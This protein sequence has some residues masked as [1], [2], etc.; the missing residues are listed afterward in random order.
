MR[1]LFIDCLFD[2]QR[3]A[4]RRGHQASTLR[5]KVYQVL[6]YLLQ[7]RHRVVSRD[8]LISQVWEETFVSDQAVK[9]V[10]RDVRR[11]TGDHGRV[12]RVIQT[13]R[14]HGYRFIA[15]VRELESPTPERRTICQ[16]AANSSSHARRRQLTVLAYEW[17]VTNHRSEALEPERL[18]AILRHLQ[19]TSRAV[20]ASWGGY[21]IPSR[22]ESLLVYFGY[23]LAQEDAAA[24]AVHA[25]V[26]LMA[27]LTTLQSHAMLQY[28]V[29][30]T[31]HAGI[32][33]G[34]VVIEMENEGRHHTPCAV[35]DAMTIAVRLSMFGPPQT[36]VISA[37]T[38]RLIPNTFT[39]DPLPT[40]AIPGV[41]GTMLLY[42]VSR[43]RTKVTSRNLTPG[44]GL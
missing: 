14:G 36:I 20:M 9:S 28:R 31:S 43:M 21:V 10:I 16:P 38:A 24:R 25:A 17:V 15:P 32:H 7:Q 3:K 44:R 6:Y 34:P 41:P 4:L 35:G 12:P 40:P 29:T 18:S 11:A 33:T 42:R 2:T 13:L 39:C 26:H 8:E 27:T 1:Y 37:A 19:N 22:Q 5:P 30:L 23:P